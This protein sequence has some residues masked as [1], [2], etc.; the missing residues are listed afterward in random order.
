[1][2]TISS[3]QINQK[4]RRQYS[5]MTPQL[6]NALNQGVKVMIYSGD[7]DSESLSLSS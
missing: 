6:T 1:M 2:R 3:D 4:Y 5:D 7:V